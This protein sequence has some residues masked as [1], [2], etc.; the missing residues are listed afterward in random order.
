MWATS[1]L[2]VFLV[3]TMTW[4][5]SCGHAAVPP[6]V[7]EALATM[8]PE[9]QCA[10]PVHNVT[11]STFPSFEG[12]VVPTING[13]NRTNVTWSL[14]PCV[15]VVWSSLPPSPSLSCN[16]GNRVNVE[17]FTGD[18]NCAVA[19]DLKVGTVA[20]PAVSYQNEALTALYDE[21]TSSTTKER[22]EL[23]VRCVAAQGTPLL[24][25]AVQQG[26]VTRITFDS[27][28]VCPN[29]KQPTTTSPE[30]FA[31][32]RAPSTVGPSSPT[33]SSS[34]D[35]SPSV[36]TGGCLLG[37]GFIATVCVLRRWTLQ[38][39]RAGIVETGYRGVTA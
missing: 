19:F 5:L 4:S 7:Y 8:I 38:R 23:F 30:T 6:A 35:V 9:S 28:S 11:L 17:R 15:A 25:G 10:V 13:G 34:M 36:V 16:D 3:A 20:S 26:K 39:R 12:L 37:V 27:W 1:T 32:S 29:A 21:V 18:G 14:S 33:S 2:S 31:P 24:V 22:L